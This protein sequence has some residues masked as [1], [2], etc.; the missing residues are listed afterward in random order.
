MMRNAMSKRQKSSA[1]RIQDVLDYREGLGKNETARYLGKLRFI[2]G[3][4]PHK[5]APSSWTHNDPAILPSITYPDVVN[6]LVFSPSPYISEDL[7]S[8]KGLDACWMQL[9]LLLNK[10]VQL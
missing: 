8:Y 1:E 10:C 7:K 6:Y 3:E 4:D 9:F 5:L 2:C